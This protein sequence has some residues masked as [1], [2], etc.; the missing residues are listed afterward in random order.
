MPLAAQVPGF[1]L[2]G[3]GD[4]GEAVSDASKAVRDAAFQGLTRVSVP[5]ASG[6]ISF[7]TYAENSSSLQV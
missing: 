6:E 5:G 4:T 3:I 1:T 7:E 2:P